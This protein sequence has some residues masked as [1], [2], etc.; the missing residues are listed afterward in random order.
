MIKTW[1]CKSRICVVLAGLASA[2]CILALPSVASAD[3]IGYTYTGND[4]ETNGGFSCFPNC[5]PVI[6]SFDLAAPI[7]SNDGTVTPTSYSFSGALTT[8]NNTDSSGTF[9]IETDALGDV[10]GWAIDITDPAGDDIHS[11]CDLGTGCYDLVFS[12]GITA[13]NGNSGGTWTAEAVTPEPFSL[14]LV[15][16]GLLALLGAKYK[17]RLAQPKGSIRVNGIGPSARRQKAGLG[18]PEVCATH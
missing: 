7:L 5:Q 16:T 18:R 3:S 14:L 9:F 15:G 13:S 17:F 4:F 12:G 11:Q 6:G 1:T 10:I 8:L 2:I